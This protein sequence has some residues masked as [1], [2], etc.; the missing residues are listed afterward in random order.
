MML[1]LLCN[2]A[3]LPITASYLYRSRET[4]S[5]QSLVAPNFTALKDLKLYDTSLGLGISLDRRSHAASMATKGTTLYCR[6]YQYGTA[7]RT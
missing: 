5:P 4:P 6:W 1:Q 2:S 7:S 3:I